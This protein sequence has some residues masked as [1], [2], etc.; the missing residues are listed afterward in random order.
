ME[1][2]FELEQVRVPARVWI[3]VVAA[4]LVLYA[5]TLENGA[6]LAAAAD[7]LHELVHDARHFVGVPCH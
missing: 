7:T 2:T 5:L 4:V 1:K 3:V 6:A